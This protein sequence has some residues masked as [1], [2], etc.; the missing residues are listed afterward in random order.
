MNMTNQQ[1]THSANRG[2]AL[3]QLST[4]M[5]RDFLNDEK[6]SEALYEV[7][8]DKDPRKEMSRIDQAWR[9][10]REQGHVRREVALSIRATIKEAGRSRTRDY[11]TLRLI[12]RLVEKRKATTTSA[13]RKG[14]NNPSATTSAG[15]PLLRVPPS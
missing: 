7:P 6:A 3:G 13:S 4:E 14:K 10:L 1:T 9:N 15:S 12:K 8:P 11:G 5:I 2:R